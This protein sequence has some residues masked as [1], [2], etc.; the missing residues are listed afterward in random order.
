MYHN[1]GPAWASAIPA[2]L[3]LAFA[4]LP[5]LLLKFGPTLRARSRFANEAKA[6][7]AK[8]VEVRKKVDEKFKEKHAAVEKPV[9]ID[10]AGSSS[11]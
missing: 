6:Q 7:L 9:E 10:S 11:A 8:L 1:L 2:F 3:A 5:F 4:P